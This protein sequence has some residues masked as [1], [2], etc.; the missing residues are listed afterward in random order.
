MKELDKENKSLIYSIIGCFVLVLIRSSP[1]QDALGFSHVYALGI[2]DDL[3][4]GF[5]GNL[6]MFGS[7]LGNCIFYITH[8][9]SFIGAILCILLSIKLIIKNIKK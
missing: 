5:L 7:Y 1:F 2:S 9:I 4:N 8:L 3:R 6:I